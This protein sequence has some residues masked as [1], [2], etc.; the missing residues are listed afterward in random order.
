MIIMIIFGVIGYLMRRF[1]Y[2]PVPL[3][4][5]FILTPLLERAFRQSLAMSHGGFMIFF[6]P[7]IALVFMMTAFVLIALLIFTL[8]K[9]ECP[10]GADCMDNVCAEE[11]LDP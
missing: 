7:P 11:W 9:K 8:I 3:V 4:F 10:K 6:R 1:E 5:A 2:E